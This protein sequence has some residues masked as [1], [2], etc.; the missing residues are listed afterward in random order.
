MKK[1]FLTSLTLIILAGG[2]LFTPQE[3]S[4]QNMS[5][6]DL[7]NLLISIGAIQPERVPLAQAFLLTLE[8]EKAQGVV[9][10]DI[11]IEA[12]TESVRIDWR[13]STSTESKVFVD[14]KTYF[15][16]RGVGT[17]HYII[18]E[19]LDDNSKYTGTITAIG[20]GLWESKD[21]SFSTK[22]LNE[23][24]YNNS[25]DSQVKKDISKG[26]LWI[27][28]SPRGFQVTLANFT[29]G[30]ANLKITPPVGIID[31]GRSGTTCS[32]GICTYIGRFMLEGGTYNN[33]LELPTDRK[34]KFVVS[35]F[36]E[37]YTVELEV[38]EE[39]TLMKD[40]NTTKPPS[41]NGGGGIPTA[42]A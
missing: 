37:T 17:R 16:K 29:E 3:T 12:E 5:V 11:E 4:A 24:E 21:F 22:K 31:S 42:S 25:S 28:G 19:E 2:L 26:E 20:N 1:I 7:V 10:S 13:T 32:G 9:I 41:S 36:G 39:K 18:I 34:Y 14:G 27:A 38:D 15:S 6:K 8:I 30:E 40:P 35:A 33:A 23:S